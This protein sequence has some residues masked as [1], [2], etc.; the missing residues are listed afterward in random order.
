MSTAPNATPAAAGIT[1]QSFWAKI[2]AWFHKEAVVVETDLKALITGPEAQALEAGFTALAKTELGMLATE[3]V[4][5]A[6][7]LNSGK[8]NFSQA[9]ASLFA[10]AKAA[11]KTLTDSTVTT[12]IAAAQQKLQSITGISTTPGA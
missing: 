5:A 10:N 1:K 8:V 3:A 7:D 4:T 12:L 2:G 9:A 6:A 11:G